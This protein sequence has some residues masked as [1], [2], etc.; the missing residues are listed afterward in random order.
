MLMN[1]L[2]SLVISLLAAGFIQ[3]ILRFLSLETPINTEAGKIWQCYKTEFV[4]AE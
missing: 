1:I 2:L 4:L 3:S